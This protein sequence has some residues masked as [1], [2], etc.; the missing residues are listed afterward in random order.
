MALLKYLQWER[1]VCKCGALSKETEQVNAYVRSLVPNGENA[2][3]D[4]KRHV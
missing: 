1:P 2:K 3:A 4:Q